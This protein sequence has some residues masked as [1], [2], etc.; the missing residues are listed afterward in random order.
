MFQRQ[1]HNRGIDYS[2][3]HFLGK[4]SWVCVR[5]TDQTAR[6]YLFVQAAKNAEQALIDQGR[7]PESHCVDLATIDCDQGINDF[8]PRLKQ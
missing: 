4:L 6:Q 8:I 5:G 7:T 2:A 3:Y 1:R